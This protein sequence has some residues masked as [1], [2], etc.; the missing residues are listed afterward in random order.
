MVNLSLKSVGVVLL[1]NSPAG[2][3]PD[4]S[5]PLL[6]VG[7]VLVLLSFFVLLKALRGLAPMTDKQG[8][9]QVT[10]PPSLLHEIDQED[11]HDT[12]KPGTRALSGAHDFRENCIIESKV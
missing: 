5:G 8:P 4:W 6:Y 3:L 7:L 10:S 12:P 2:R 1:T 9:S 11:S